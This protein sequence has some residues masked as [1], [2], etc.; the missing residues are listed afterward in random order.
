MAIKLDCGVEEPAQVLRGED[1][2]DELVL[3]PGKDACRRNLMAGIFDVQEPRRTRDIPEPVVSRSRRR[4]R[5]RPLDGG[6][7]A[8]VTFAPGGGK[9]P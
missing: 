9:G 5:L 8:D 4:R 6:L 2:W 3:G 1:V 7:R